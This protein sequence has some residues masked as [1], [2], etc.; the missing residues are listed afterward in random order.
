MSTVTRPSTPEPGPVLT[1]RERDRRWNGLRALMR[2]REIDVILVGTFQGRER[3][4]SYLIDDFHDSLV[5]FP[6]EGEPTVL[7]FSP[8]R[9]SRG[10]ESERRGI[11]LW[12]TD[13]RI[14]SGGVKTA[15]I[16]REKRLDKGNVGLV[17]LGP[18]APGEM[19]GLIPLGF[20]QNL[21]RSLP[22]ARIV[23]F[24]RDFTDFVL[25]KGPEE[26]A[27][28]RFAAKVSERACEAMIA[29][30]A[31]GVSEAEIY[32]DIL[33][34]IHRWGCDVRYPFLSLQSGADNIAWG[35]PRWTIRAEPPRVIERGDLV[36]AEI[37]TCYGGQEA[38]VQM[39][40]ALDPVDADIQKCERIVGLAYEA[41]LN[42]VRP[43]VTFADVVR[44]MEKPISDAGCWSR[45]PLLHTVTFGATGFTPVNR[46][47]LAGTRVEQ[48]EAE[49]TPGIRRGD[50]V[51]EPGMGLE[52]EPNACLGMKRVNIGGIVLVTDTGA[53][54]LNDISTRVHHVT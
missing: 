23:D 1:F 44:A 47:Q 10:Y 27:L 36:Q 37:H 5:I 2:E 41:G 39:S 24:T 26:I 45:T 6:R 18:T 53:E 14:G 32:A 34:E 15:E 48:L 19:E 8:V 43:G 9:I 13:Y 38:Q 7:S 25:V 28:L 54:A 16:L 35:V 49:N 4:E 40:V 21:T 3:V 17:G 29:A 42:A 22:D 51:L 12:V 52:L 31:P 20:H 46:E 30:C 11:E 33:H 50:L